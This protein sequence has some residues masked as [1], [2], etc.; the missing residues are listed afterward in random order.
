LFPAHLVSSKI[1][2]SLNSFFINLFILDLLGH[3]PDQIVLY[4]LKVILFALSPPFAKSFFVNLNI[5]R[6]NLFFA[7]CTCI[8]VLV[9]WL[10][11]TLEQLHAL[12]F[13]DISRLEIL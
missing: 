10:L 12:I 5:F 11:I 13:N 6:I 3:P 9:P 8:S 1:S 4:K 2:Q 7:W